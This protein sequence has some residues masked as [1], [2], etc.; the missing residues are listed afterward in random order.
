MT[1]LASNRGQNGMWLARSTGFWNAENLTAEIRKADKDID[2]D[3]GG[4]EG[5]RKSQEHW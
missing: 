2:K 5:N 4:L 3:D 1:R